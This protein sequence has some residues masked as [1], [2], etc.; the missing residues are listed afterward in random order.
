VADVF[1]FQNDG[2]VQ[3][4]TSDGTT[5]WTADMSEA[6][7]GPWYK[8]FIPD[9]QGGLIVQGYGDNSSIWIEKL[10]GITGAP[11]PRCNLG[12]DTGVRRTPD[13]DHPYVAVHPD[14]TVFAVVDN[15]IWLGG[16][17]V[18]GIDP[19]TGTQKF[20]VPLPQDACAG[21]F[22]GLII[23]GDGY[24]YVPYNTI[25]VD[26]S[27][28]FNVDFSV[29]LLRIGTDGSYNRIDVHD[30]I[31]PADWCTYP[32]APPGMIANADT[33]IVLTWW[34]NDGVWMAVTAGTSASIVNTPQLPG[35]YPLAPVL[36]AQDGS[37]LGA[38]P[39]SIGAFD[40]SGN[41]RWLVEGDEPAIATADGGVIGTSGTTYD[42]QG[43]ATGSVGP[44]PT[45]S[46]K[47]NAYQQQGSV[48]Q[49]SAELLFVLYDVASSFW[50][51][52][53][54]N[55]SHNATAY[56]LIRTFS[57]N[58]VSSDITVANF[59]KAGA[60]QQ[61]ITNVLNDVLQ[62]LNS[63]KYAGCSTWLTG[64]APFSISD[65]IANLIRFNAYGHGPF[66]D[67]DTAA[68]VGARNL[69]GT[70]SGLPDGAAIA[71]NDTG[72]FFNAKLGDKTF[73]VGRRAYTGG[74]LKAQAA[75]LVHE[76]SHLMKAVG[77]A[78][79]FQSDAGNRKSGRAND[80]LVNQYCG[81]LIGGLK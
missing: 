62:G 61:A 55:Y 42:A 20:R 34:G 71:V 17:S 5:A 11:Y 26:P 78:A 35:G 54:G 49:T 31:C 72:A 67:N 8:N 1:A 23:A 51:V 58:E 47:G 10:D 68:F 6:Y 3:A 30:W 16:V 18:V 53:G 59:S 66:S 39:G 70:L 57:D 19:A 60:N 37:F 56:A 63:G 38:A 64:A 33:G 12:P 25:T 32:T 81:K 76:L 40:A 44:L 27:S 41:V 4:I 79:G 24:A 43:R 29:M 9:F 52:A 14:G 73:T 36:Q 45:Y 13:G 2:T 48:E 75:I 46:W 50:A 7:L 80:K 69:D 21:S 15:M 74:T 65:S 28:P 22:C 77:G